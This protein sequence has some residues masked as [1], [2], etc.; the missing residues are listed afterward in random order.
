MPLGGLGVSIKCMAGSFACP[1]VLGYLRANGGAR[2]SCRSRHVAPAHKA[3]Q[4]C[5]GSDLGAAKRT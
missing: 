3:W 5:T 1:S 4:H 2:F